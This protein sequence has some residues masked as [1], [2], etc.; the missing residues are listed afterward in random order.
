MFFFFFCQQLFSL[1]CNISNAFIYVLVVEVTLGP[2]ISIP[3][4]SNRNNRKS[5]S[6]IEKVIIVNYSKYSQNCELLPLRVMC[7][8]FILH[9]CLMLGFILFFFSLSYS[10]QFTDVVS[11]YSQKR[12][13]GTRKAIQAAASGLQFTQPAEHSLRLP[14]G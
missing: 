8:T 3:M 9:H 2:K 13:A 4:I 14:V 12:N 1:I 7:V 10:M 11:V 5:D 6:I